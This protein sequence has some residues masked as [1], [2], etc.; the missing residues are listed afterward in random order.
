LAGR[1]AGAR[2]TDRILEK[3]APRGASWFVVLTSYYHSD[4]IGGNVMGPSCGTYGGGKCI[5]SF[6]EEIRRY[7]NLKDLT[8]RK[9][10]DNIKVNAKE[11]GFE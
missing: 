5:Q 6:V 2:R 1:R 9:R 11:T 3:T 10:E 7:D 8:K 4:Q